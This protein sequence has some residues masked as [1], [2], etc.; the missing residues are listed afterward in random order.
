MQTTS[1][2]YGLQPTIKPNNSFPEAKKNNVEE[3]ESESKTEYTLQ[4][5]KK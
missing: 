3:Q 1:K 4:L 2:Q 5:P